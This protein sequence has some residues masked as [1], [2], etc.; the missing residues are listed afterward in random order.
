MAPR[1]WKAS[2]GPTRSS[3]AAERVSAGAL[4]LSAPR[5]GTRARWRARVGR[6]RGV[7]RGPALRHPGQRRLLARHALDGDGVDSDLVE[8]REELGRPIPGRIGVLLHELGAEPRLL[9]PR[10]HDANPAED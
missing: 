2:A 8:A 9:L 10:L 5:I 1:S 6:Y 4:A 3:P 7:A